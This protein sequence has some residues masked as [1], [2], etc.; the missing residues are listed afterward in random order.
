M[1]WDPRKGHIPRGFIGATGDLNAVE[2]VFVVAEPGDPEPGDHET[3][4]EAIEH[5][6]KS[7]RSGNGVFHQKA[8]ILFDLCWPSVPFDLQLQK[9]WLTESVLCSAIHSTAKVPIEIERS[10]ADRYL[11]RQLELFPKA[12]IVALG[13]KSG[14]RLRRI[15][16]IDFESAHAF[17]KPGCYQ[18]AAYPSWV[19]IGN[20]LQQRR[21][22]W[23]NH[24]AEQIRNQT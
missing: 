17:G 15:G 14:N 3:M 16:V 7:F 4:D 12:L 8:R 6:Y 20:I 13:S 2:V 19:R 24:P 9:F 1:R 21:E 10:C 18:T 5:A 11:R 22:V 23:K